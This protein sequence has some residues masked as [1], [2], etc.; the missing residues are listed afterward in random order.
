MAW[1]QP[2]RNSKN[3]TCRHGRGQCWCQRRANEQMARRPETAPHACGQ[4][5]GKNKGKACGAMVR[6]GVCPC[7]Y[8]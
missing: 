1:G 4:M 2:K 6:G 7:P 5:C 8:C 3:P